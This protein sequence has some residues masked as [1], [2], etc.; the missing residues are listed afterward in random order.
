MQYRHQ[1]LTEVK[2]LSFTTNHDPNALHSLKTRPVSSTFA[3]TEVPAM[4]DSRIEETSDAAACDV[5]GVPPAKRCSALVEGD[6][7]QRVRRGGRKNGA[8]NTY[9]PLLSHMSE[10]QQASC[11]QRSRLY[12]IVEHMRKKKKQ[13]NGGEMASALWRRPAQRR[14]RSS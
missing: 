2:S 7:N 4:R 10:L 3:P 9:R 6:E 1:R 11:G 13:E 8:L 5:S 14:G 12:G